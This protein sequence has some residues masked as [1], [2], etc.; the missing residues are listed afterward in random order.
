MAKE[1]AKAF[2]RSK[3]W[4]KAR[5]GYITSVNGLCERC[6]AKGRYVPGYIV[7]H[8]QAITPKNIDDP[9]VTLN[10]DNFEYVCKA[11]HNIEHYGSGATREE[12]MF[13]EN[14]D[15]IER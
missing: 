3:A 11:C 13:D 9:N 15:L 10:W 2:Y 6:L 7:H 4:L 1:Y 14:G 8:K 5:A 12:L